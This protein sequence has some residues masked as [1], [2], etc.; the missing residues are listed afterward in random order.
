MWVA[1]SLGGLIV[2]GVGAEESYMPFRSIAHLLKVLAHSSRSS[3]TAVPDLRPIS[4]STYGVIFLSTPHTILPLQIDLLCEAALCKVVGE[5]TR[6]IKKLRAKYTALQALNQEFLGLAHQYQ[7]H[8]FREM[9]EPKVCND[10][11]CKSQLS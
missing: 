8:C 7:L 11:S 5:T 4:T 6:T 2:K 10:A 9:L 1:H 3:E